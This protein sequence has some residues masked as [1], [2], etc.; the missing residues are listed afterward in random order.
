[1][2]IALVVLAL[3]L[4]VPAAAEAKGA[5]EVG[6]DR[7]IEGRGPIAADPARDVV[8]G[9]L[10]LI[11]G[12]VVQ[13]HRMPMG[14]DGMRLGVLL[15][16][17]HRAMLALAPESREDVAL[18]YRMEGSQRPPDISVGFAPCDPSTP[19]FG[20]DGTVGRAT[21]WAGGLLA[22][23]PTCAR[24]LVWV[25]DVRQRDVRLPLGEP[26]RPPAATRAVGCSAGSP[27][28]RPASGGVQVG[29]L[30]LLAG[31]LELQDGATAVL[32]VA[33]EHRRLAGFATGAGATRRA[34]RL[35]P[36]GGAPVTSWPVRLVPRGGP[37][38]VR[39]DVWIGLGPARRVALP[40]GA[41][42][43]P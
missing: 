39:I 22:R 4:V 25:D 30:E 21:A 3:L 28:A 12:R 32:A 23:R 31:A 38:C 27:A 40:V 20:G 29:A 5:Q 14:T 8:R 16:A 1:M 9:P 13:R 18:Q 37:A 36:C 19:R 43:C 17:G 34:I 15:R 11:G 42:A 6:C 24:L 33:W 2:P 26:C 10:A 35:G 7:H 41:P